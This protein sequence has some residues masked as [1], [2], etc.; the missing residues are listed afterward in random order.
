MSSPLKVTASLLAGLDPHM[1]H[2][3]TGHSKRVGYNA[4]RIMIWH[5]ITLG[6]FQ[7]RQLI[8]SPLNATFTWSSRLVRPCLRRR[9]MHSVTKSIFLSGPVW[10]SSV[11]DALLFLVH[12]LV[13]SKRKKNPKIS[14]GVRHP[15]CLLTTLSSPRFRG[16]KQRIT[17]AKLPLRTKVTKKKR[18]RNENDVRHLRY[19]TACLLHGLQAKY[20]PCSWRVV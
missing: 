19:P 6:S 9:R 1:P 12:R 20:S 17:K 4:V 15:S 10:A 5:T 2:T 14:M 7:K 16:M 8:I 13:C 11:G 18:K 3:P